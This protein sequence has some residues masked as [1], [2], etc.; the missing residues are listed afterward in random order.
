[1]ASAVLDF[2]AF[3]SVALNPSPPLIGT[4]SVPMTTAVAPLV[5]RRLWNDTPR[6]TRML[7]AMSQA[8]TNLAVPTGSNWTEQVAGSVATNTGVDSC[9]ETS[10][11]LAAPAI[12]CDAGKYITSASSIPPSITGFLPTRSLS[13]PK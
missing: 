5:D 10:A 13:Q 8:L 6:V 3:R 7:L 1:M 12:Q 9:A 2:S 4:V 11:G